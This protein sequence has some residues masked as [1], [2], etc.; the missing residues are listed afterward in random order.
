[1]KMAIK[2]DLKTQIKKVQGP[3]LIFGAGGFIG[4]NLIQKI[5]LFRKDVY[6]V[7][8]D[9]MHNWRFIAAKI[10]RKHFLDC[11]LTN[12][13]QLE[14]VIKKIKPKTVF[15]LAAYGAYSK[16]QEV[17]KIYETNVFSTIQLLETLRDK[18]IAAYIHAGSQS[19]YGL[20]SSAPKE[21]GELSPNSH[22]AVSKVSN[23]FTLKYYGKVEKMPVIHL[24]LYSAFGPWEEQDRLIPTLLEK[25]RH[26][27][28]PHFVDPSISRDFIY[29]DDIVS[30]FI[31]A[32]VCMSPLLYGEV[33]NVATGKKTTIRQ[34]ALLVK[35]IVKMKISPTF[36]GM[37]NRNWDL[38]DWYGNNENIKKK[39]R[40]KPLF[41]LEQGLRATIQWQ[42]EVQYNS[43]KWNFTKNT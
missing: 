31:Y 7:S 3:I 43:A 10:P 15:N 17:K 36:G 5:L 14:K 35:K 39:L 13:E 11:D 42:K 37:K 25:A 16:Q 1:M 40:W 18:K 12:N 33:F 27:E 2:K 22:Y 26:G 29:V 4:V 20:N 19:E 28:F 30:A 21:D 41:T 23:Y 8:H 34:L 6:G 32:A 9:S 24:R 38:E